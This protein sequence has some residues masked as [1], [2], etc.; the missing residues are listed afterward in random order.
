MSLPLYLTNLQHHRRPGPGC[1][2]GQKLGMEQR[3]QYLQLDHGEEAYKRRA[4]QGLPIGSCAPVQ[5]C[6]GVSRW[7]AQRLRGTDV[8]YTEH[9]INIDCKQ[10]S[11]KVEQHMTN[12]VGI[13]LD[14][15][16]AKREVSTLRDLPRYSFDSPWSQCWQSATV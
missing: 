9:T 8:Q 14:Q 6:F 3:V 12:I 15:L 16:Q 7:E 2:R 1:K 11:Y 13:F 10:G 4:G 5:L